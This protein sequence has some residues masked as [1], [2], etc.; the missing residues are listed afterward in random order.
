MSDEKSMGK[1]AKKRLKEE[2]MTLK[3]KVRLTG[4]DGNVFNLIGICSRALK[5][6]GQMKERSE[7][8]GRA[9]SAK[10][11]NEA[12]AILGEYCEVS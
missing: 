4:K 3:P 6:V 11:Y 10:S 9:M 7:M 5:E 8:L 2:T 1:T 12:L